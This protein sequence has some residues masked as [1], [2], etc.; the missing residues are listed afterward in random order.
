VN[1]SRCGDGARCRQDHC[2]CNPATV[3]YLPSGSRSAFARWRYGSWAGWPVAGRPPSLLCSAA[4]C[5]LSCRSPSCC[6]VRKRR[7]ACS[8]TDRAVTAST[9]P[10]VIASQSMSTGLASPAPAGCG[11]WSGGGGVIRCSSTAGASTPR[12]MRHCDDN[13]ELSGTAR[14]NEVTGPFARQA[15]ALRRI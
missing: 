1:L 10:A 8:G 12:S 11:W 6:A 3:C 9:W 5:C 2:R 14:V 7:G 13:C 4:C 15:E